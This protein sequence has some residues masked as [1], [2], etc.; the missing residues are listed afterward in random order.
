MFN[1]TMAFSTNTPLKFIPK[2]SAFATNMDWLKEQR[3]PASEHCYPGQ[4]TW[5]EVDFAVIKHYILPQ[6]IINIL[7]PFI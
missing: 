3:W 1:V 7:G 6:Y 5:P 4:P 2:I